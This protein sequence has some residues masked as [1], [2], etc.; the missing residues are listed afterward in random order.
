MRRRSRVETSPAAAALCGA[1]AGLIGGL[2]L[3]ALD[4]VVV[5]R[6]NGGSDNG[7]EW[8]DGVA[9]TLARLGV[10]LTGRDRATAGIATGLAYAALLGAGYGLARQ[11]LRGS[12]AA[13]GLI[14]AALV[15]A[16]SLLSPEP[17]RRSRRTRRLSARDAAM[18]RVSSVSVF[19]TATAAAYQAL[20]RRV[21]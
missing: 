9:D 5:P 12:P 18:R 17:P 2:T 19:G 4:R 6:L 21:G 7:R 15:Y 3:I 14:D 20:S 16:A 8:D 11:R 1:A 10:R 13:R